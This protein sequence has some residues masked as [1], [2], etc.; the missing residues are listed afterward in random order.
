MPISGAISRTYMPNVPRNHTISATT[1]SRRTWREG[2][3]CRAMSALSSLLALG[4]RVIDAHLALDRFGQVAGTGQRLD[5]FAHAPD[6]A[7]V[8]VGPFDRGR[9]RGRKRQVEHKPGRQAGLLI[10]QCVRAAP[11][12]RP[13]DCLDRFACHVTSSPALR[14]APRRPRSW[15]PP[16]SAG[17][18]RP[19][20]LPPA[21]P[22]LLAQPRR[23]RTVASAPA[24]P[25]AYRVR[26]W[27]RSYPCRPR[28]S[29]L[30]YARIRVLV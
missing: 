8:H 24:S 7:G 1:A 23:V 17:S 27:F 14:S 28:R 11:V 4:L 10:C 16:P 25:Y 18:D 15:R 21:V 6:P 12:A 19:P 29:I 13:P 30:S 22:S 2:S 20:C 26:P 9:V 5:C 3:G